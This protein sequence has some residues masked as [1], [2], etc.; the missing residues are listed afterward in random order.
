MIHTAREIILALSYHC[1][2]EWEKIYNILKTKEKISDEDILRYNQKNKAQYISIIDSNYPIKFK[3][4]YKPPFI[5]YYYGNIELLNKYPI[6][7][8]IGTRNPS[9][10]QV[11]ESKKLISETIDKMNKKVTILSGMA[12]GLDKEMMDVAINKGS[13]LISIIASG[14]DNPYPHENRYIY[15]YCKSEKG[16]VISEYPS[17]IQAKKENFT[18]RNRLLASLGDV[19]FV[20]GGKQRSGTSSTCNQA[21][22]LNKDILALPC[23][24]DEENYTNQLIAD[25]AKI[26]LSSQDIIDSLKI[27]LA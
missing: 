20:G 27:F 5:I 3:R 25:G 16:L 23:H 19:I 4:N 10:Y 15:D 1:E 26:V 8:A 6:L 11:K 2:G 7:T 13:T 12:K 24:N 22:E 9:N 21:L 14:I 17:S 18:F